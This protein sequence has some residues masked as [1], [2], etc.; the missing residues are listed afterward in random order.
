MTMHPHCRHGN[1]FS[2]PV[3]CHPEADMATRMIIRRAVW[4]AVALATLIALFYAEEDWRGARAW[5]AA[6][7]QYKGAGESLDY[8]KFIPPPIPDNENLA[9]LPLFAL[10]PPSQKEPYPHPAALEEALRQNESIPELPRL[11]SWQQGE[12]PDMNQVHQGVATIYAAVFA[13]V[14]SPPSY[15]ARFEKVY[16]FIADLRDASVSHVSCRFERNYKI[17]PVARPLSLLTDQI[18]VTRIITLD[19][20]LALDAHQPE[21]AL[22][23][24]RTVFTLSSGMRRD[25]SLVAGLI[26]IGMGSISEEVV[27]E[28]L[29]LHEWNDAQLAQLQLQLDQMDFLSTFGLSIQGETAGN[30]LN[31]QV[32]RGNMIHGFLVAPLPV[33]AEGNRIVRFYLPWPVGW[34]A[35]GQSQLVQFGLSNLATVDAAKHRVYPDRANRLVKE[36]ERWRFMGRHVLPWDFFFFEMTMGH[37]EFASK[38]ARA[39]TWVDHSVLA[40]ALERYRLGHGHYP[41]SLDALRPNYCDVIPTDVITGQPYHY[42]VFPDGSYRIYSVGWNEKDDGGV[43]AMK[44]EYGRSSINYDEGDWVWF[45][46]K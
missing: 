3:C 29:M 43:L 22:A 7:A 25:P 12:S 39:Q 24:L 11:G 26:S 20:V 36:R 42:R 35:E 5:Q 8:A 1:R 6:Q 44:T 14:S 34:L 32:V 16:P 17:A 45:G 33:D 21:I 4:T 37:A 18:A 15:L 28:G 40:C 10:H 19:A 41:S 46:P 23:D 31:L 9:A 38:C 30:L 2:N 27:A 13:G